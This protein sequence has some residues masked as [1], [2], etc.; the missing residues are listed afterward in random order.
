V[1]SSPVWEGMSGTS[2]VNCDDFIGLWMW[3]QPQLQPSRAM[4]DDMH[5]KPPWTRIT[6]LSPPVSPCGSSEI[7]HHVVFFRGRQTFIQH[8]D[9]A[10][11]YLHVA[12]HGAGRHPF[13][14]EADGLAMS[15]PTF[16]IE[17]GAV[18]LDRAG[19]AVEPPLRFLGVPAVCPVP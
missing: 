13:E 9:Q 5:F 12:D 8:T 11:F 10:A 18:R 16:R 17:R 7:G 3:R 15:I 4:T 2:R 1:R 14:L 19:P 6:H